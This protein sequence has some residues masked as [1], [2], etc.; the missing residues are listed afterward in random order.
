MT[1]RLRPTVACS[2][3]GRAVTYAARRGVRGLTAEH[4]SGGKHCAGSDLPWDAHRL[5]PAAKVVGDVERW[6]E[7]VAERAALRLLQTN[8][9]VRRIVPPAPSPFRKVLARL[10]P[11][12][13]VSVR[14]EAA[15]VARRVIG[16]PLTREERAAFVSRGA[17]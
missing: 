15:S 14:F 16:R 8:I 9:P 7:Q 1:A 10:K 12:P 5:G 6:A 2:L 4:H 3:C 17:A 13:V 11:G